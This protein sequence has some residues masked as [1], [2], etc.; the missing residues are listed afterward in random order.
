MFQRKNKQVSP[1]FFFL[2]LYGIRTSIFLRSIICSDLFYYCISSN[3]TTQGLWQLQCQTRLKLSKITG[4]WGCQDDKQNLMIFK[5]KQVNDDD[6]SWYRVVVTLMPL[7]V[8]KWDVNFLICCWSL[9][10]LI[11]Y[12]MCVGH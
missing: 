5:Q 6:D 12:L 4:T 1:N 2:N 11:S 8:K 10:W 7:V 3:K 9:F